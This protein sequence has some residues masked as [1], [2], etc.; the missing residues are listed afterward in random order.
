MIHIILSDGWGNILFQYAVGRHLA[1]KNNTTVRFNIENYAGRHHLFDRQIIRQLRLFNIKPI[2]YTAN[3][4]YR[5]LR[6]LGVAGSSYQRRVYYEREHGFSPEVLELKDDICL[7]GYFQSDKYFKDIEHIIRRDLSFRK[8]F[9]DPEGRIYKKQITNTNSVS[10]HVRR[11]DYLKLPLFNVCSPKYYD[12][13]AAYMREKLVS[14]RF[15]VFSDDI[16]WCSENLS[17]PDC[18]FVDIKAAK[19][20]ALIDFQLMRLC[21]HHIISNSTFSWWAAWLN[22]HNEKIVVTPNRWFNDESKNMKAVR[23]T[24]PGDWIRL[25]F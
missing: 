23:D 2:N 6:H 8:D 7:K 5:I 21:K 22:D 14:P 3:I 20:N 12:N 24:I 19:T 18:R 15:F 25:N 11:G 13:A 10:L 17:I 4:P 16:K 1:I 9:L